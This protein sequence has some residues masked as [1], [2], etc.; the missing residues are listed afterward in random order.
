[1]KA[2]ILILVFAAAGF[3]QLTTTYDKFKDE[4][5][6]AYRTEHGVAMTTVFTYGGT[7]LVGK[8]QLFYFIFSKSSCPGL[9]FDDPAL[10][11]LI[12]GERTT[13]GSYK[14]FGSS[15]IFSTSRSIIIKIAKAKSVEFQVGS[16]EGKLSDEDI[17]QYTELLKLATKE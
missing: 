13:I 10:I 5:K 4:T 2:L 15:A 1:M 6:V 14:G 16:F 17:K 7:E 3:G 11:F 9:C 8:A 12:D